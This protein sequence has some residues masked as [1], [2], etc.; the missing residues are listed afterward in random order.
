M[1]AGPPVASWRVGR[2]LSRTLYEGDTCVGV[3]VGDELEARVLA[4][5]VVRAVNYHDELVAAL[6]RLAYLEPTFWNDRHDARDDACNLLARI[7]AE[8]TGGG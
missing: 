1:T 3:M 5:T 7:D 8:E 2:S 6:R 4:A